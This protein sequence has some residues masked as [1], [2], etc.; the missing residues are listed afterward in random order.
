VATWVGGAVQPV[1]R[2]ELVA[3]P[4]V[5]EARPDPRPVTWPNA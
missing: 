2:G 3:L 4:G 5:P 1:A